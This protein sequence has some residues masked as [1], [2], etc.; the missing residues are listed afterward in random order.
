MPIDRFERLHR[1]LEQVGSTKPSPTLE[2]LERRAAKGEGP[3]LDLRLTDAR[4][5]EV[6][7]ALESLD[8][9]RCR[10][11]PESASIRRRVKNCR[12]IWRR[13]LWL[14]SF[15]PKPFIS[16]LSNRWWHDGWAAHQC[17]G[18]QPPK[19]GGRRPAFTVVCRPATIGAED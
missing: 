19:G 15:L 7:F 5:M 2:S 14:R 10:W 17:Q 13:R 3:V 16:R 8:V 4:R 18:R 1:M 12:K 6:E 9:L 11:L